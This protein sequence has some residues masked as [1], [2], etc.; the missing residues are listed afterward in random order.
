MPDAREKDVLVYADPFTY[1][2]ADFDISTPK[3]IAAFLAQCAHESGNL[4]YKKETASG[5]AYDTGTKAANLGNT[6]EADG[7][8]QKYKGRGP[9]EITGTSNYRAFTDYVNRYI[10]PIAPVDFLK[11]P[12]LLET[13]YWG[14]MASAWFWKT[15]GLNELADLDNFKKITIKINGGLTHYDRRIEH[16]ERIKK[17]LNVAA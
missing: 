11:N 9:I 4:F 17:V 8:G 15:K 13:P 7:D 12:E 10:K 6:P 16:W 2:M 5:E 3:R 14:C 1:A